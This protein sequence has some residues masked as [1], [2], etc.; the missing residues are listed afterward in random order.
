MKVTRVKLSDRPYRMGG[1]YPSITVVF[2]YE[3]KPLEGAMYTLSSI[4]HQRLRKTREHGW[5]IGIGSVFEDP[6]GRG[7]PIWL[8]VMLPIEP[9]NVKSL[10]TYIDEAVKIAEAAVPQG[11]KMRTAL[12]QEQKRV[13]DDI[14]VSLDIKH[15]TYSLKGAKH[16]GTRRVESLIGIDDNGSVDLVVPREPA[17]LLKELES[18]QAEAAAKEA[19]RNKYTPDQRTEMRRQENIEEKKAAALTRA[20]VDKLRTQVEAFNKDIASFFDR[21]GT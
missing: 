17:S 9:G 1:D 3:T 15:Y 16:V 2:D 13:G 7:G 19:E 4:S 21:E 18:I 12:E 8:T 5:G 11:L 20:A 10:K 14:I 6:K